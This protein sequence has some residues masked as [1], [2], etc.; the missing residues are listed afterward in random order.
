[1]TIIFQP[2]KSS[3]VQEIGYPA[4][5]VQTGGKN[6][7]PRTATKEI[8]IPV[9]MSASAKYMHDTNHRYVNRFASS[10][11]FAKGNAMPLMV[12]DSY[13]CYSSSITTAPTSR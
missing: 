7:A 13:R 12:T 4:E 11:E 3:G 2:F 6:T 10:L 1:M 8:P 5:I 9:P